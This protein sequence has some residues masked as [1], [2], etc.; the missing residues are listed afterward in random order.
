LQSDLADVEVVSAFPYG[1]KV[2]VKA[3]SH[4]KEITLKLRIPSWSGKAFDN[5]ENGY[6]IYTGVFAGETM[7]LDFCAEVKKTYP[8]AKVRADDGKI[9]LTYGPLVLCAEGAD[10]DNLCGVRIGDIQS[11]KVAYTEKEKM[12]LKVQVP[13]KI[14]TEEGALYSYNPPVYKDKVMTFIPYFAWGN[15]G[16]NDMKV[17]FTDD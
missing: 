12:A 6:L 4:G 13:V 11:A 1:G 8:N 16:K 14:R 3:D 7:E 9:A 10:N 5:A 2:T 15:R 17:F